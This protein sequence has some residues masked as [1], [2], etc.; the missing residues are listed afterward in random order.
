MIL[1]DQKIQKA[2]DDGG[3]FIDPFDPKQLQPATYDMRVGAEAVTSASKELR[4]L[5]EKGFVTFQPGDFGFIITMEKIKLNPNYAARFGLRSAL[6]RKGLSAT[7]GP[8]IDPG[9]QGRLILGIS[10]L[11]PNP[12]T[13]SYGE[14]LIS[15][16][17]HELPGP[18]R[19]PYDGPFQG[20]EH[21]RPEEISIVTEKKG[22]LLSEMQET[23]SS[24]SAN[25]GR[26]TDEFSTFKWWI[27][28]TIAL[29]GILTAVVAIFK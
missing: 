13:L 11:T 12:V 15:I 14:D 10:N 21:L 23:L 18:A 25:V 26:L 29:L 28:A 6:A 19:H 4:K 8:Q 16:E 20:V 22:M 24:L 5:D 27:G 1:T 3:I 7:A 9:Y 17:F 2:I